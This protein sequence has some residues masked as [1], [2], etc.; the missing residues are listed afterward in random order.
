MARA[1]RSEGFSD[2]DSAQKDNGSTTTPR[3]SVVLRALREASGASQEGWAAQLGFGRSTVQRWESGDLPPG[4]EA[5]NAL[6]KLCN[7]RRLLRTFY[8]VPLR[9]QT[10]TEELIRDLL[11]EARL[12]AVRE[13]P[14]RA[15]PRGPAAQSAKLAP[16]V[17]ISLPRTSFIGRQHDLSEV[18][19]LLEQHR[20]VSLIGP[21]GAGKTRL[22]LQVAAS[23]TARTWFVDLSAIARAELVPLALVTAI[24]LRDDANE[25]ALDAALRTLAALD[26]VL[27]VDNCEHVLEACARIVDRLLS[28]C[29]GIRVLATTRQALELADE[30]CWPLAGLEMP[31]ADPEPEALESVSASAAVRLFVERAVA[32]Q[33]EFALRPGNV[34]AVTRIC[35]QLDGLPLAIELAAAR[36]R[37]L[38]P[39]QLAARLESHLRLLATSSI[40]LPPRQQTLHAALDWSYELLSEPEQGLLRR[41]AVFAGSWSLEAAESAARDLSGASE[42]VDLLSALVSRS[43]VVADVRGE[44]ARY[45]LLETVRQYA[46]EKLQALHEEPPARDAHLDWYLALAEAAEPHLR[47]ADQASWLDQL[48]EEVENVRAALSW[49]LEGSHRVGDALR[50]ASALRW[51]WFTRARPAEGRRWLE[52]GLAAA[53]GV[54]A[55]TRGKALDSAAA[56]AHGQGAY[57][58]AQ[59]L[60]DEG[61]AVWR[62]DGD[63][64]RMAAALSTLGILAKARGE[65]EQ[66][67]A[68]MHDA[69]GLAR[70]CGESATQATV[71]NN[72]AALS[73]DVGQ[74]AQAS[75][76]LEQSLAIKRRLEDT[77]GIATSLFNLGESAVHLGNYDASL[78]LLSESLAL[79]RRLGASH[80][81][82]QTLHS[83]GSVAL[84]RE[85]FDTARSQFASARELFKAA[86]DGWGQA[87]CV[88]G[89]AQVAERQADHTRAARLFGAADAW[90]QANGAPIPPN[91]RAQYDRALTAARAEM[92]RTAF[93]MAWAEGRA[94]GLDVT[95]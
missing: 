13:R 67:A 66:A 71:L 92:D 32:V 50:L 24:G 9:G 10:I 58:D 46:L 63:V 54:S 57:A 28:E 53:D 35:R 11:A 89:L 39:A 87:L 62:A 8:Q 48:E 83:L 81:I 1:S 41:L 94:L 73:M 3:W 64:R 14:S 18:Q 45:R 23:V 85:D 47:G 20:L 21:G 42:V 5:E 43:L 27:L 88:E 59:R 90:R 19:R 37:I 82:A 84:H 86:G 75:E 68:L 12:D 29:H 7:E 36:I 17:E 31:P 69:L 93:T 70:Q 95:D 26:G 56:L 77:A 22:A 52:L 38:S 51:F 61:L 80:R 72:L 91:D 33:P 65:H 16:R 78:E 55:A 25:S 4:S 40:S 79:F 15:A 2:S 74:Y 34:R 44:H 6:L 30:V 60:Q 76:Y 49:A